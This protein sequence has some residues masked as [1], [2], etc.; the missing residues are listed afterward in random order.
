MSDS[1]NQ[2]NEMAFRQQFTLGEGFHGFT[3]KSAA[4]DTNATKNVNVSDDFQRTRVV[5]V[6]VFS[7]THLTNH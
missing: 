1:L 6:G 5:Q 3:D 4:C 2:L 7:V